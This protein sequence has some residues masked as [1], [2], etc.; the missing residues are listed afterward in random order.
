VPQSAVVIA[1]VQQAQEL[2]CPMLKKLRYLIFMIA[3]I[4]PKTA[5]VAATPST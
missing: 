3:Y 1:F 5:T 4:G 2:L